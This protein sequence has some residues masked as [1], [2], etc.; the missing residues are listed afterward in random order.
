GSS[1]TCSAPTTTS[2]CSSTSSA[3]TGK[4]ARRS[5]AS[6]WDRPPIWTGCWPACG[7]PNSM[8]K[9]C[10]PVPRHTGICCRRRADTAL[11]QLH[12]SGTPGFGAVSAGILALFMFLGAVAIWVARHEGLLRR[13]WARACDATVVNR[14]AAWARE[15]LGTRGLALAQRLPAYE[16]AGIA[17]LAGSAVVVALAAGFTA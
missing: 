7:R 3:T 11:N 5:S 14:L 9:R 6:S 17:L 16:V 8:S 2:P 10:S 15:R 13:L 1:S 4:P 12:G